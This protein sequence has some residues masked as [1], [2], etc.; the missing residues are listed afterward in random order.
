MSS[1]LNL[2]QWLAKLEHISPNNI[3][4]GLSRCQI[5]LDRLEFNKQW[6]LISVAGTNGKGSCVAMLESILVA[7]GYQVAS[8]TS[9]HIFQ[10]N[11]RIK[12]NSKEVDDDLICE[13]F[14]K[15]EA[16]RQ[17]ILLTY[18]E[19]T[20]LASMIIFDQMPLDVVIMEVGLGGRL[21][22]VNVLDADVAIVTSIGLD[23]QDWLGSTR[24]Q[25]AIEKAGICR[26]E[27][28]CVI[29]EAD[30]PA[31]L[32]KT[33]A[34][35]NAKL[36]QNNNQYCYEI[37]ESCWSW[38]CAEL[39]LNYKDI[40]LPNLNG[41]VQVQNA[42][43]VLMSLQLLKQIKVTEEQIFAGLQNIKISA[44]FEVFN[45]EGKEV[46]VDVAHNAEAVFELNEMLMQ[47][48]VVGDDFALFGALMDKNIASIYQSIK[49]TINHWSVVSIKN[50]RGCDSGHIKKV[51][52]GVGCLDELSLFEDVEE[53]LNKT[54]KKMKNNDRLIVFGSFYL[55]ADVLKLLKN[56]LYFN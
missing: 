31:S 33:V 1:P 16:I 18:F 3:D 13:A 14:E 38:E 32:I 44:R 45:I 4:L 55:V 30:S 11:E 12:I 7:S 56:R 21:D 48:Q 5:I 36:Y 43:A 19:Y 8:Y 23:H 41:D 22:A 27:K 52:D 24:E 25:I 50:E 35:V 28:P 17:E 49:Q 20:T 51:F 2:Q 54:L 42:A 26:Q 53:A 6:P 34:D 47:R 9:P 15:I 37:L 40:P 10:F 39:Q 29:A 46:I